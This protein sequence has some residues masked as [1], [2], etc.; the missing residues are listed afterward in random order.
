MFCS[1]LLTVGAN[2]LIRTGVHRAGGF[3]SAIRQVPRGVLRLI[4]QPSF[5][6][7][8]ALYAFASLV[9]FRVIATEP[10]SLA[11]PI[12]MS[13]TFV[14]VSVGASLLF[15]EGMTLQKS[16]GLLVIVIGIL[17]ASGGGSR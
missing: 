14:L 12:L 13:V 9:W 2:L 15:R 10:L 16:L 4:A 3:P 7:G 17:I 1:A 11:Y 8:F 6:L 5:D